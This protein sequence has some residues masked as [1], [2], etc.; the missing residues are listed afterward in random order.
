MLFAWLLLVSCFDLSARSSDPTL[1]GSLAAYPEQVAQV[2]E[3]NSA[4]HPLLK[5]FQPASG[6]WTFATTDLKVTG[7]QPEGMLG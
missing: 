6:Q 2:K 4:Y 3:E 1:S 5:Y 7:A